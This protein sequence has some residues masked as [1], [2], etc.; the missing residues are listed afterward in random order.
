[1]LIKV[2][3]EEKDLVE[4]ELKSLCKKGID[5][6]DFILKISTDVRIII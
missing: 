1:M 3:E 2:L 6:I 4:N 5:L